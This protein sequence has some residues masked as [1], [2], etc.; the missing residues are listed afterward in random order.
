MCKHTHEKSYLTH[1]Q[2]PTS[3]IRFLSLYLTKNA[4]ERKNDEKYKPTPN[5]LPCVYN[6][7]VR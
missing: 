5:L 7:M 3:H 1:R 2:Q 6:C 4:K